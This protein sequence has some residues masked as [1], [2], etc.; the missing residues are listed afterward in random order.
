MGLSEKGCGLYRAG[1]FRPRTGR[2]VSAACGGACGEQKASGK[3]MPM[4]LILTLALAAA[5]PVADS[6][7][8]TANPDGG[9]TIHRAI[10]AEMPPLWFTS[11]G[12]V[13]EWDSEAAERDEMDAEE[14][15]REAFEEAVDRMRAP[16]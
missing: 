9:F 5:A 2:P 4:P 14:D 1:A 3:E 6:P 16:N 12:L 7:A 8:V 15:L 13:A 10:E 11:D